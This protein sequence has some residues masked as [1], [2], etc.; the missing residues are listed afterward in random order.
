[1]DPSP[2]LGT[3]ILT[4]AGLGVL[5]T[6]T[7]PDHYIPF[8]AMS[9]VGRWSVAKTLMVTLLCGVGHVAGSVLLGAIAIALGWTLG[10]MEALEASRGGLAATPKRLV[11]GSLL[12]HE[13]AW[14]RSRDGSYYSVRVIVTYAATVF[15]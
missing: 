12:G 11:R 10:G 8:I 1:M 2:T 13:L 9:R 15:T 6:V 14:K 4:A 5:H 3:L 7:G